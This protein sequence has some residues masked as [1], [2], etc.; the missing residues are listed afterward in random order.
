MPIYISPLRERKEDIK[1]FIDYFHRKFSETNEKHIKKISGSFYEGMINYDWPGN[2]R[3]L[4]NVMQ[5][6]LN[7]AENNSVLTDKNL[8]SYV[9]EKENIGEVSSAKQLFTL[10]QMEKNAIMQTLIEVNDNI[11]AA[12]RILGIGRNTLYRKMEKYKI[13]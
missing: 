13:I 4:Q 3:E 2:V 12:A 1:I 5:L 11:A 10:E 9:K 7:V 6:V 8:P